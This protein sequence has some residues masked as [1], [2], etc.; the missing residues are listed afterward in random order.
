MSGVNVVC[1]ICGMW[2]LLFLVRSVCE[3]EEFMQNGE[4]VGKKPI[5][6]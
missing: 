6:G 3:G 2:Q 1:S 4:I 5:L